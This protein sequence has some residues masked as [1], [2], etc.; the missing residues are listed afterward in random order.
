MQRE[1]I[2]SGKGSLCHYKL[3]DGAIATSS[4]LLGLIMSSP[5]DTI[6]VNKEALIPSFFELRSGVAGDFLQKLTNYHCRMVI[7]GDFAEVQSK[8][9]HAL[10]V[11][12][13]RVGKVVFT[14]TVDEAIALLK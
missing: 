1:I 10:I 5:A 8:S 3:G 11:E 7:L 12:S 14:K 2:E 9:L 4:D 6:V 13:N